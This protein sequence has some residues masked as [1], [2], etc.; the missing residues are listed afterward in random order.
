MAV[1]VIGDLGCMGVDLAKFRAENQCPL[2]RGQWN[3]W[4]FLRT[5]RDNPDDATIVATLRATLLKLNK[6][7]SEWGGADLLF[8]TTIPDGPRAGTKTVRVGHCDYLHVTKI[9]RT[10]IDFPR[11]LWPRL[12]PAGKLPA[13]RE[14]VDPVPTLSTRDAVYVEC[15]FVWRGTAQAI[16]WPVLTQSIVRA[17][18]QCPIDADWILSSCAL[19]PAE[20]PPAEKTALEK[21]GT[22]L[23]NVIPP[24][25]LGGGL[26][27]V[28]A[29]AAVAA[30][31][32]LRR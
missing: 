11:E 7:N 28:G 22:E 30:L 23:A 21:G 19:P 15:A 29:L 27:A 12:L 32:A 10:R 26:M 17:T 9:S 16:P 13:R 5:T 3:R 31:I 6:E 4:I 8:E 14:S 24:L 20:T 2:Y 1:N 25:A 18:Q